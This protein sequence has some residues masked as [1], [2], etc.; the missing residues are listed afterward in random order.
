MYSAPH[1]AL[2]AALALAAYYQSPP[3]L[4]AEAV[5][6]GAVVAFFSHDLL[7]R[8]GER[9]Y[10]S[11]KAT[12]LWEGIPLAAAVWAASGPLWWVFAAGWIGG[13]FMDLVDKKLGLSVIWPARFPPT[14][15]F[16]CHRRSPDIHLTLVQTKVI[17]GLSAVGFLAMA[18]VARL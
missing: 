9:G 16:A 7:D 18:A 17:A 1:G 11:L 15:L 8:I 4:E 5:A 3:G 6:V 13:T 10:G 14:S 2:G 12:A